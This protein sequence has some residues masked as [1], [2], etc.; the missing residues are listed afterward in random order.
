MCMGYCVTELTVTADELLF[1][2]MLTE[3]QHRRFRAREARVMEAADHAWTLAPGTDFVLL[4]HMIAGTQSETVQ[5]MIGLFFSDTPPTRTPISVKLE[6]QGIAIPAGDSNYVVED[7][8]V[9][10]VDV[11]AVSI[12]LPPDVQAPLAERAE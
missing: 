9:L 1:E 4:L 11:D 8:Y 12:A 6:A 10:P 5:P 7:S 2:G 3:R